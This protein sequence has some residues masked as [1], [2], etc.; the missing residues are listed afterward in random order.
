MKFSVFAAFLIATSITAGVVAGCGGNGSSDA[1]VPPDIRAVMN[2]ARYAG[3]SWGLRVVDAQTGAT[4]LDMQPD[5]SFYVGSVRKLFS[6]G[7]L[8]DQ[9][10]PSHRYNTPVYRQG[11]VSAGVLAGDLVLVASGDLTMGGR[12]NP[13]GSIAISDYDHNEANPLGNAL[14][15]QPDPLAGYRSLAQQV[16]AAGITHV[17]GDVVIDDRLFQP[18]P[19][20]GEFDLRP[21]FV[22]DN[23]IDLTIKPTAPGQAAS[24]DW[25][26][27]SAALN[28][29]NALTT[30]AAGTE[31]GFEL[32]P[33]FSSCIGSAGCTTRVNGAIPIDFKPQ[34]TR[35]FPLVKS[36]RIT[37]PDNYAR[38]VFIEA[39]QAAGV[40][41]DAVAVKENPVH[42]LPQRDSWQNAAKVA[43]L[44][45]LPYAD[46]AKL[47]L[48]VSYNLGADTSMLL[49][50]KTQGVD[51]MAATLAVEQAHLASRYGVPSNEYAFFNGSGGGD[52][53]A[54]TR[55]V[56]QFLAQMRKSAH[57]D[58]YFDALPIL[59]TDGSL[60]FVKDYAAD[61]SLAG[62]TGQ[63]RAKTGTNI[64]A[65]D[66][67]LL[68]KG[69]AFGGY[70]RTKSGRDL[71]YVLVVNNA[72]VADIDAVAQ[73]FQD[74]GTISAILWRDY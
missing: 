37:R 1:D 51:S 4:V 33:W 55:A 59:G 14:L 21:I 53:Q 41:V 22:N 3:A 40:T 13:D 23:M 65:T 25:R 12:T 56:T 66:A 32:A 5:R 49:W 17:S 54:V 39:L 58:T 42:L 73:V 6:V 71:N 29:D 60:A 72:P 15:T 28:V 74:E 2:Q 30:G 47:I 70:I 64:G 50:G 35:Q 68:L 43:E 36:I 62:A 45:G 27:K 8:L 48:K 20:R 61:P 52:T 44:P 57:F 63:V 67:G 19:Y 46:Y 34:F 31:L 11:T 38:T 7:E 9:V 69:Q 16:A 10:G 18:F 24:L 26:P